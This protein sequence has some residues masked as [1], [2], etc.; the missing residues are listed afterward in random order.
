M[1]KGIWKVL[2]FLSSQWTKALEGDKKNEDQF[3]NLF[4]CAQY[5]VHGIE[6]R[7]SKSGYLFYE[8]IYY[9]ICKFI[10][11]YLQPIL[12]IYLSFSA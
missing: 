4:L 9:S 7:W 10:F 6:S 2:K 11:P 8:I 3:N 12:L 5:L 1:A